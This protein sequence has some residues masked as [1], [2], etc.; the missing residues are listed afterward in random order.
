MGGDAPPGNFANGRYLFVDASEEFLALA[1]NLLA[2]ESAFGHTAAGGAEGLERFEAGVYDVVVADTHLP[3]MD[4][5]EMVRRMRSVDPNAIFVITTSDA[6][7]TALRALEVG[8]R[9]LL[10]KP[11]T[12]QGMKAQL[13]KALAERKQLADRQHL[14]GDLNEVRSD[15]QQKVADRERYLSHLI[16]SAPFAIVS[17]DTEGRILTFNG[18]AEAMYGYES[19]QVIDR[20]I[21]MLLFED[22]PDGSG[23]VKTHHCRRDGSRLPVLVHYGEVLDGGGRCIARLSV[24]EDLTERE[25]M[26]L[27]LLQAERLLRLLEPLKVLRRCKVVTAVADDLPAIMGDPAQIEQA[28]RNLIINAAHAMEESSD[29]VLELGI[30]AAEDGACVEALVG[31][32]GCGIPK[33][34]QEDI[35]DD[36]RPL[37]ELYGTGTEA[38]RPLGALV[39][40]RCRDLPDRHRLLRSPAAVPPTPPGALSGTGAGHSRHRRS[41]AAAPP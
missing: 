12:A 11:F 1:R 35:W 24:I 8:A 7:D 15:L 19:D 25:Q 16:D 13:Q 33:E 4:G 21:S 28:L 27:Q 3:D 23:S 2:A 38:L 34:D 14:L 31:D 22:S 39:L 20:P 41:E 5:I 29:C 37:R 6:R 40:S 18:R 26:E 10:E 36:G 32:T 9:G 17:T 30:G